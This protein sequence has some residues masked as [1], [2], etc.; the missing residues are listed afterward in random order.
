MRLP[1]SLSWCDSISVWKVFIQT[2]GLVKPG[3][4]EQKP[5]HIHRPVGSQVHGNLTLVFW[6]LGSNLYTS[7]T[8]LYFPELGELISLNCTCSLRIFLL[9]CEE[10][11]IRRAVTK[12]N[13]W[14]KTSNCPF[15][16]NSSALNQVIMVSDLSSFAW[17][18]W[19]CVRTVYSMWL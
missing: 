1:N 19:C 17:F 16:S 8:V 18:P 15:N 5:S 6:I 9:P 7:I 4:C 14:K 13:A 10:T 11:F 12:T 3:C 2:F